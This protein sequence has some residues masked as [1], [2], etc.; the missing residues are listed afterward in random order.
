[1]SLPWVLRSELADLPDDGIL[2]TVLTE[3]Q[4]EIVDPAGIVED[5]VNIVGGGEVG[6]ST[7][8]R[9]C[10]FHAISSEHGDHDIDVV[11][12]LRDGMVFVQAKAAQTL[13]VNGKYLA[14]AEKMNVHRELIAFIAAAEAR[15][16][17]R[18]VV[19][20]ASSLLSA[21]GAVIRNRPS[22]LE[23]WSL[24]SATRG[25]RKVSEHLARLRA[26]GSIDESGKLLVPLPDDVKPGSPTDV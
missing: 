6:L 11:I 12:S 2:G 5:R 3:A 7:R 1:M 13:R 4:I 10:E 24:R 25:A 16:R 20:V 9:K 19:L 23:S 18:T 17:V 26:N 14:A 8:D 21:A 22:A 15:L